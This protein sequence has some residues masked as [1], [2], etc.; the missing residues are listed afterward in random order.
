MAERSESVWCRKCK[1]VTTWS[2][3]GQRLWCVG[4]GEDFPCEHRCGHWD[5]LE[6]RGLAAPDE[7]GI[8]R[9]LEPLAKHRRG[10][11]VSEELPVERQPAQLEL[12]SRDD[13]L[14]AA[15]RGAD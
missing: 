9:L 12:G 13:D 3:K 8:L 4:C 10:P 6:A 1:A 7:R 5:C 2:G 15:E 11:R 14:F